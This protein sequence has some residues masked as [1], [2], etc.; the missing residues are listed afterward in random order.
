MLEMNKKNDKV[1][2]IGMVVLLSLSLCTSFITTNVK[3]T[4][5]NDVSTTAFA[6]QTSYFDGAST[7]RIHVTG[8]H[9][10]ILINASKGKPFTYKIFRNGSEYKSYKANGHVVKT[11]SCSKGDYSV[12]AYSSGQSFTGGIS[13]S[14]F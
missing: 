1:K 4:L 13:T 11:I 8:G 14:R 2:Q 10:T 9:L 3:S 6:A 5:N 7:H 12:H